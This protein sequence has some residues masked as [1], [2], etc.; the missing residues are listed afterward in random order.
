MKSDAEDLKIA[1]GIFKDIA[2][3][4]YDI[5]GYDELHDA[6]VSMESEVKKTKQIAEIQRLVDEIMTY[7]S[8]WPFEDPIDNEVMAE[9]D[10][11]CS[12]LCEL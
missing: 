10:E 8:N 9:L 1:K 3:I 12:E 4:C 2:A 11:L 6:M 5:E 7:I